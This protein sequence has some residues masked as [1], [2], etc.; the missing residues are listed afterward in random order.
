VLRCARILGLVAA[1]SFIKLPMRRGGRDANLPESDS[2]H[3]KI[4]LAHIALALSEDDM[5]LGRVVKNYKKAG[6]DYG[7]STIF[8][9][10]GKLKSGQDIF[11]ADDKRGN[12]KLLTPEQENIFVG[13]VLDKN[14]DG[15]PVNREMCDNFIQRSFGVTMSRQNIS[16]YLK[17]NNLSRQFMGSRQLTRVRSYSEYIKTYYQWL[18]DQHNDG[19]FQCEKKYLGSV[20]FMSNSRRVERLKTYS[21]VGQK[22]QKYAGPKITYTDCFLTLLWADGVNRTP[23]LLFTYNPDLDPDG[24]NKERVAAL[25]AELGLSPDRIFYKNKKK[26]YYAEGSGMVFTALQKY[27]RTVKWKEVHM[28]HDA[29]NVFKVA[30]EDIFDDGWAAKVAVSASCCHGDLSP[31]DNSY[32]GIV[33]NK[34]INHRQKYDSEADQSLFLLHLCD[35]VEP[36]TIAAQFTRNFLLDKNNLRMSDVEKMLKPNKALT[37]D[38]L[39]HDKT[40]ERAYKRFLQN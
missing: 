10:V 17:Q 35:K 12:K 1:N 26:T 36:R 23:T 9:W 37:E 33:K 21:P 3:V 11:T 8:R 16:K 40:C 13:Y 29:G 34:W 18:L 25:C 14:D 39:R 31:N 32:H 20:D 30:G 5:E 28:M 2:K 22:Q 15:I 4:A 38:Q 27:K 7:R 6:Y 24:R 19:F